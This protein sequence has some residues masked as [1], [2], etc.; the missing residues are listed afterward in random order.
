MRKCSVVCPGETREV[1][2]TRVFGNWLYDLGLA[3]VGRSI[4]SLGQMCRVQNGIFGERG[5][6]EDKEKKKDLA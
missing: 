4:G 6:D 1:W 3:I 2:A 5:R